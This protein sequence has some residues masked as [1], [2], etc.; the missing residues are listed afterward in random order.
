MLSVN[1]TVHTSSNDT[2]EVQIT[3]YKKNSTEVVASYKGSSNTA[4]T[5]SADS[6]ELWSPDSPTLYDVT[7]TLGDEKISSYTAFRT[8]AK[9]NVNGVERVVLNGEATFILGTLDQGFWPDGIYTPPNREAMVYDLETLKKLGFNML[10]KH[11]KV[12][13]ALFYQACDEMGLMVIQDMPSLRPLATRTLSNCT[14]EDILPDADQQAEFQRQLELLVKQ[15]RS[16]P[17]IITWVIYNE[18]WGQLIDGYPEFGLTDLVREL[19]PTRLIDSTTG[20]YD[21]GAGDYSDNHHYANPQ[22][23]T[24][25]YSTSSSPFDLSRIGFQGE[26]GGIGENTTIDHLWYVYPRSITVCSMV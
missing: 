21:H 2:A 12:E 23:G 1:A 13:N 11:I 10:R 16:Y 5:F 17:S 15:H 7:V 8:V 25:F 19:D 20:W 3:I 6:P 9:A 18:G 24:P 26:F 14:V 22:C 4:L